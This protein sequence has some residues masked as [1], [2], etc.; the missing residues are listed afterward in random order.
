MA[1]N[2]I[3]K[4]FFQSKTKLFKVHTWQNERNTVIS[5]KEEGVIRVVYTR[6]LIALGIV[7]PHK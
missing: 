7:L 4:K 1:K 3:N 6:V 2:K 5:R